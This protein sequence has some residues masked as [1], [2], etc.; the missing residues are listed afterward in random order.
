MKL[1]KRL[2]TRLLAAFQAA[3]TLRKLFERR[4]TPA[5]PWLLTKISTTAIFEETRLL[6][7][8][9]NNSAMDPASAVVAFVGFSASVVTLCGF[10]VESSRTLY[11]LQDK[12]RNAPEELRNILATFHNLE[13]LLTEMQH[14]SS[15]VS[16][17]DIPAR[18][19]EAWMSTVGTLESDMVSFRGWL[20]QHF[21][22]DVYQHALKKQTGLRRRVQVFFAE[23][24]IKTFQQSITLHTA[25]LSILYDLISR[26][27]SF[28]L[29]A[30][31]Y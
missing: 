19:K 4:R 25:Q 7:S 16:S 9:L 24:R 31:T 10:V 17:M 13:V 18:Q 8:I 29:F 30:I 26:L 21:K 27:I 20:F 14:L 5:Q 28:I 12:V 2:T 15:E 1:W 23:D 3:A 22:L 11:E 6:L